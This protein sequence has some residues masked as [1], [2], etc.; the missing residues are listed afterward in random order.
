MI[1]LILI[2]LLIIS[3]FKPDVL[4]AKRLKEMAN[5]EQKALLVKNERKIYAILVAI[6]ESIS[7]A[8]YALTYSPTYTLIVRMVGI[9]LTV[10]FIVLFFVISLPAVRENRKIVKEVT[11]AGK[12]LNFKITQEKEK[13]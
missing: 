5:E 4:L 12:E 7:L 9:I 11:Y 6:L 8:T 1:D 2:I 10:V 13:Q 3:L